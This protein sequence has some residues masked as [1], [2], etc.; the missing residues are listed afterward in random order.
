M[1]FGASAYGE[2]GDDVLEGGPKADVLEGGSGTNSYHGGPGGDIVD[3]AN[4][5]RGETVNCGTGVDT[6]FIDPGDRTKGCERVHV[7]RRTR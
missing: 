2:E 5:Y 6:A 4:G 7:L 3:A 1:L